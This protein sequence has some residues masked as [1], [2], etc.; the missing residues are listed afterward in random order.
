MLLLA[1]GAVLVSHVVAPSY[2][3][4][5]TSCVAVGLTW[6]Q[7]IAHQ[8]DIISYLLLVVPGNHIAA[9]YCNIVFNQT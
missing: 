3:L 1:S 6:H 7:T 4:S 8:L 9:H 2:M 5:S